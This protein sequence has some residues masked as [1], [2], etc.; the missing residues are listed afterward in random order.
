MVVSHPHL[1]W[2]NFSAV[3]FFCHTACAILLCA[4][5]Y[6]TTTPPFKRRYNYLTCFSFYIYHSNLTLHIQTLKRERER[7]FFHARRWFQWVD[8]GVWR[9]IMCTNCP[10]FHVLEYKCASVCAFNLLGTWE[11]SFPPFFLC[12]LFKLCVF[13]LFVLGGKKSK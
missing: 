4:L 1:L 13:Y 8:C 2:T 5:F 12:F 10:R 11:F 9:Y 7:D 3:F 6:S